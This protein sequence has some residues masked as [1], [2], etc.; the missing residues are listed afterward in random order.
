MTCEQIELR[1]V[2]LENSV[3]SSVILLQAVYLDQG[4]RAGFGEGVCS[5][6][7]DASST[8]CKG[9]D[10]SLVLVFVTRLIMA[11]PLYLGIKEMP[12]ELVTVVLFCAWDL[13]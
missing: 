9:T 11:V 13:R 8:R 7:S 4:P 10:R 12:A 6:H 5:C 1:I 2:Y 3:S